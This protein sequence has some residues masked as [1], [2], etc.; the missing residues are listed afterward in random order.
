MCVS[1][2]DRRGQRIAKV[3]RAV[4]A[5]RK[6]RATLFA[7]SSRGRLLAQGA[8][9]KSLTRVP[10]TRDMHFRIGNTT[11]TMTTTLLLRYV[12][13][14]RVRLTDRVSRWLPKYP[15]GNKITLGHL[16]NSTSGIP[17]YVA[18]PEFAAVADANPFRHWNP[19]QLLA[20]VK[21]EP[22]QFKP[23]SN[24]AFS[25][26]N[27][28]LLGMIL[29]KI[30]DAPVP[31]QLSRQIFRPLGMG[32]TRMVTN[33]LVDNPVLHAFARDR[34]PYEDATNWDPTWA[35]YTGNTT[36]N[37]ADMTTWAR[38][39]GRGRLL[40][41]KSHR[42]QTGRHNVGLGPLTKQRYYAMG[43]GVATGWVVANP[44]LMGYNGIVAYNKKHD[45]T[46]VVAS[47]QT[48]KNSQTI[49]YSAYYFRR[50]AKLLTGVTPD[51]TPNPRPNG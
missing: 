42:L 30:G 23:G 25:D 11:E 38:A 51:V 43:L 46:I 33:G 4:K 41:K 50:I 44:Q 14:G 19:R 31:R 39:L 1:R 12:D 26:S 7:V 13:S 40:S 45:L 17:D 27:F 36:S 16:A 37:L 24:W 48:A 20:Y 15:K 35:R 10:A 6:N 32:H 49:T 47:T 8:L 9:G 21:D 2:S 3:A 18:D 22:L 5:A 34:G 29:A 28:V